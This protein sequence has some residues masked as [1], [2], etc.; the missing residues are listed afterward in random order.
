[1]QAAA[2]Q[3]EQRNMF[4]EYKKELERQGAYQLQATQAFQ[5]NI[6]ASGSEAAQG[7][8]ASGAAQRQAAYGSLQNVPL[9][10]SGTGDESS[11]YKALDAAAYGQRGQERAALGA[12]GDWQHQLGIG[13]QA[14]QRQLNQISNF[15]GGTAGVL[16]YRMYQAQH[17]MD[18]LA[19]WGQMIQSLGGTAAN[20]QQLFGGSPVQGGQQYGSPIGPGAPEYIDPNSY[21]PYGTV[22]LPNQ[23][24]YNPNAQYGSFLTP[25]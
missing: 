14:V 3:A 23:S 17:S 16:P 12:Y 1:M 22:S 20:Y 2:A 25:G 13:N 5:P 10:I 8:L 18:E 11:A 9:S 21:A 4:N 15:A 6:A 19:F 7:D 24:V